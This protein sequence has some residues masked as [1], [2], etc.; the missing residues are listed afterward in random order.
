M[1]QIEKHIEIAGKKRRIISR[2]IT[3]VIK[4]FGQ[5]AEIKKFKKLRIFVTKDPV[6][7]CKK[8]V[9]VDV[10]LRRH[11]EIR[12][13]ICETAPSFSYWD[14]KET[15]IIMLN[16]NE[17]VFK[18]RNYGAIKGLF[19]HELM[20]LLNKL[21]RIEDELEDE[22]EKAARNIFIFLDKHKEVKPFTRERLLASFV[23]VTAT[24]LLF[25]K[26]ILANSRAMS[27]GFDEHLYENYKVTLSDVKTLKFT[28]KQILNALKKDKKHVLDNVF[29]V[30]LGLNISWVTFKMFQNIW[31]KDL[32]ELA[33]I[34]VPNIIKKN[35]KGIL[36]EMLNLRSGHDEA[37]I[38]KILR[39]SQEN[40][41]KVVQ[42][43]CKRLKGNSS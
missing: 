15:P 20:H 14:E 11:G 4:E 21:D 24:T 28:E 3:D 10:K 25:I 42:Y 18:G 27:F 29:L 5:R 2:A 12:E 22:A 33:D 31:Y 16:A 1:L 23:R 9:C 35:C 6:K 40:Y 32:Q 38:A 43:F 41:F 19:A 34:D 39:V 7:L 13:W 30:Y 17:K 37:Q 26:D 36:K 8:I